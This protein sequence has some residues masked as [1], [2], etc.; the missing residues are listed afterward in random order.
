MEIF[1]LVGSIMVDSAEANK[2]IQKTEK[3][4]MNL[5][6]SLSNGVTTATKW[7]AGLTAAAAGV[8]AA[9]VAAAKGVTADLDAIDKGSQRMGITAESYQELAYAAGLCGVN[10]GT[11]EKAAKKLEGTGLSMDMAMENL[12]SISDETER[13]K[14]AIDLFGE[15]VAYEMTPL[16]KIGADEFAAMKEE[17]NELG[18]VMS[19]DTVAAGAALGDSFS[20]VEQSL[21]AAGDGII[22]NFFPV[23]Q[24]ILDWVLENLPTIEEKVNGL[25][26]KVMPI[27][28]STVQQIMD[29]LPPILDTVMGLLDALL[30]VIEPVIQSIMDLIPPLLEIIKGAIDLI[31]PYIE[32]VVNAVSSLIQGFFSLMT[33]DF[34]GFW[35]GITGYLS[36][37][38]SVFLGLGS[39]IINGL[40]DGLKKAWS[41][42]SEWFSGIIDN[43]TGWFAGIGDWFGDLFGGGDVPDG[44]HAAGLPTVPYDNYKANLHRGET[45]LNAN[46][47]S[48]LMDAINNGGGD[49]GPV[50]ITVQ[51]VLD[52]K[53][54]GEYS[55]QYSRRKARAMGV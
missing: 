16:L 28:E 42:V 19:G 30:P 40:W 9:M 50:N 43:I 1:K 55:Y 41:G 8:G 5:G 37:I 34:E 2:S 27:V 35:D 31:Q 51:N 39:D 6:K 54:I 17:A 29:L 53:I 15:S 36:G 48:R 22:A 52:G 12:M 3:N 32:P 10:M 49:S 24:Q 44:S 13:T 25:L 20:K 23:I 14:A 26:E 38:V 21:K 18:I 46:D 11:M 45:V 33:G 4:T 47:T 7:A